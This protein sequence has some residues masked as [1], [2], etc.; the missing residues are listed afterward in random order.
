M[1]VQNEIENYVAENKMPIYAITDGE[2][3]EHALPGWQPKELIPRAKSILIFG[4]P[5][6]EHPRI[7]DEK[8]HIADESWWTEN[9]PVFEQIAEWRGGII[10]I[11]DNFGFGVAN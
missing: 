8:S 5:F 9:I 11:L 3:L 10:N 6:I 4:R 1:N 2:N 7:V